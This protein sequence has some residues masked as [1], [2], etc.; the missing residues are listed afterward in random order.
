MS[1]KTLRLL[2]TVLIALTIHVGSTA[3]KVILDYSVNGF[4]APV[5]TRAL[6]ND[7][8]VSGN[9]NS[10]AL[11]GTP[12]PGISVTSL[13][14]IDIVFDMQSSQG[15]TEYFVDELLTNNTGVAWSGFNMQIGFGT[16]AN[17]QIDGLVNSPLLNNPDFD[18]PNY[19][20]TPT[21]SG[22]SQLT[23]NPNELTWS[24][25]SVPANGI[26][27]LGLGFSL[28]TPDD[29]LG[30]VTSAFT[31]REIP[32]PVPEPSTLALLT[33]G[34]DSLLAMRRRCRRLIRCRTKLAD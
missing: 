9:P 17:F 15:T 6:N 11:P 23:T 14:P 30:N 29:L 33:L 13:N 10:I 22:F 8:V 4:A 3:A 24:G 28:D 27:F 19:D 5:S 16:G 25:G 12:G 21:S 26:N 31:L 1:Y 32:I 7:N 2:F 20:P 18:A 34:A